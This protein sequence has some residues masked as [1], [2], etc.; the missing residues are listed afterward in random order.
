MLRILGSRRRLC[1]GLT[2]RD[3]LRAGG[4]GMLGA[5]LPGLATSQAE[6]SPATDPPRSFGRAKSVILLHLYGSPSQ[7]ET[8]DPKPDAPDEIRGELGVIDSVLPGVRVGELI[9]KT[10]KVLDRTTIIRS[11]SHPFPLHGVAY[12]LT[13][14]PTID[15]PLELS[16]RDGRHWPFFGSVVDFLDTK[17]ERD[18]PR[19]MPANMALPFRFSSRRVGEVPRAGPYAAFLGAE[20]DPIWT[21]WTGTATRGIRKTLRDMVYDDPDPYIEMSPDSHFVVPSASQLQPEITL[22]RLHERKT[23]IDQL[24]QARADLDRTASGRQFDRYRGM[25]YDMLASDALRTALDPRREPEETRALYGPSLFGQACLTAR[26][27]VEAG[28]R[29]VTV[30]WDEWGLAGT[31]WD[32]HWDHFPRM[33]QELCPPF[34]QAF[35]GLITD[36]D[37]RGLLDDTL[38][39]L[40][41][42]HGRTPKLSDPPQGGGGRNHWSRAYSNVIAGAGVPRG[43]V[44]GATD[45]YAGEVTNTPV[46]PKDLQATMYH[47]LGIDHHQMVHDALGRPLPLVEGRVVPELLA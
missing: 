21:D 1:D 44:V 27:L 40:T 32:T 47:L 20:Y 7:I 33:K 28:T 36:M 14:I 24:D 10:A 17:S 42:E 4:L 37:R 23:L 16:P 46:S 25:T 12:A 15:V 11:M 39:V 29:V 13:G 38:V 18:R 2:R 6:A 19:G 5:S 35:Y 26:R 34:D 22:D 3:M 31:G 43:K 8:F 41:S 30:F 45:R 9:P